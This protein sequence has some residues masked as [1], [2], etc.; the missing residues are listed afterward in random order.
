MLSPEEVEE[1]KSAAKEANTPDDDSDLRL[2]DGEDDE[3]NMGST[4]VPMLELEG[5]EAIVDEGSGSEIELAGDSDLDLSDSGGSDITLDSGDSGINLVS[6]SDSGLALDDI[7]LDIGGSAI[8]SSLSLSG[9]SDP[10]I[11]L[12]G[13]ADGGGD[14]GSA[15]LQTD[16]DFQLTPLSE[17]G[18]E[19]EGDSSSQVIALDAD[20]DDVSAGASAAVSGFEEVQFTEDAEEAVVL[21]EE[22]TE[23]PSEQFEPTYAAAPAG[24][25]AAAAAPAEMPYGVSGMLLLMST[26]TILTLCS[27]MLFDVLTNIWTWNQDFSLSSD[28]MD[29]LL[30]WFGLQ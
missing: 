15:A 19:D 16:D 7:P 23:A 30:Q 18:A 6:P 14:E 4:D 25:T 29:S 9:D 8:L 20:F 10:E 13:D 5:D 28:L 22:F 1:F 21:S 24:A 17:G 27:L 26:T 3:A 2:D 11:S 12:V